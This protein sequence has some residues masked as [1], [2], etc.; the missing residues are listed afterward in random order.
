[1]DRPTVEDLSRWLYAPLADGL[2]GLYG[3]LEVS[4]LSRNTAVADGTTVLLIR[5][6]TGQPRAVAL[7]SSPV[8]PRLVERAMDRA[9]QAK[10]QLGAPTGDRILDPLAEG[11]VQGISYA[12]LP[13]CNSLSKSRLV[14][15]IQ[16]AFLRPLIFDW[17]WCVSERTV[18]DVEPAAI[19]RS[20]SGPVR[21]MAS[22]ATVSDGVRAAAK[23]AAERLDAG[24]WTPRHVLMHGDLW[25]GNVLIRRASCDVEQR[26]W[27]DGFVVIDWAGS[28][29]HGY[30]LYDLVRFAISIRLNASSLRREVGRYCR[31]LRCEPT[32]ARS[33][34][35]A[36]LGHLANNLDRF[37]IDRYASM[38]ESCLTTLERA[39]K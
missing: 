31:L 33:Y 28:E 20:F 22:L 18:R 24:V 10:A 37:P 17:L 32:D 25:I 5:D 7:C 11:S 8:S 36:A 13:Y 21:T 19:D 16:H 1:M 6:S 23:Q 3:K 2:G 38:A 12:V 39:L 15:P 9:R 14:G 34:L 30:A 29:I 35:V 27:R 4:L 26:R